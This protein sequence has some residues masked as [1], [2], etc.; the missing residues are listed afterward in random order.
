MPEIAPEAPVGLEVLGVVLD[1]AGQQ[2]QR[3]STPVR[4]IITAAKAVSRASVGR[5][6]GRA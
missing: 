1:R 6:V 2:A 5:L 3:R 4:M